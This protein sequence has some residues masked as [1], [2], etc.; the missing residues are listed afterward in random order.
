MY[1]VEKVHLTVKTNPHIS[2]FKSRKQLYIIEMYIKNRI[3]YLLLPLFKILL[4]IIYIK[5]YVYK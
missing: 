2:E 4:P 1:C 5:G 3:L